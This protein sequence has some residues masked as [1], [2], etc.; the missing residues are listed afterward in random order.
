[1]KS[2]GIALIVAVALA[3]GAAGAGASGPIKAESPPPGDGPAFQSYAQAWVDHY[4]ASINR[5]ADAY[6]SWERAPGTR[7]Q[8]RAGRQ[9]SS[10]VSKLRSGQRAAT[11]DLASTGFGTGC[12]EFFLST[13]NQAFGQFASAARAMKNTRNPLTRSRV[14]ERHDDGAVRV[15]QSV[16]RSYQM[17]RCLDRQGWQTPPVLPN[18]PLSRFDISDAFYL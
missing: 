13:L 8:K 14:R 11:R 9:Y 7:A 17:A 1:M 18:N 12:K 10:A 4:D 2:T 16:G 3:A 5:L 6:D 15:W